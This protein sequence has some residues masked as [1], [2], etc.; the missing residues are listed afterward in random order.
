MPS[1]TVI[2][3]KT[4]RLASVLYCWPESLESF[5][6]LNHLVQYEVAIAICGLGC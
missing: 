3:T 6:V 2:F 4:C 1:I 5:L